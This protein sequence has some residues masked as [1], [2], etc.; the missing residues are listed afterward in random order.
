[1]WFL[2]DKEMTLKKKFAFVAIFATTSVSG[3]VFWLRYILSVSDEFSFAA[4]RFLENPQWNAFQIL[5]RMGKLFS[6]GPDWFLVS[7]AVLVLGYVAFLLRRDIFQDP[8]LRL[9]C[10][11]LVTYFLGLILL[12]K[13]DVHELDRL[14]SIY[15]PFVYLLVFASVDRLS[16]II[17][18]LQVRLVLIVAILWMS[19]PLIRTWQNAALWHDRSCFSVLN[20]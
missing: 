16:R 8:K 11:L 18:K 6:V 4:Y 3:L 5:L 9:I 17:S 15:V 14:L 1:L 2:S 19:Y 10:I 12:G 20:K 7:V 13:L